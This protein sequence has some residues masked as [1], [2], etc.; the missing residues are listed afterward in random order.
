MVC[1]WSSRD[2][3]EVSEAARAVTRWA[4]SSTWRVSMADGK[5]AVPLSTV[6]APSPATSLS[7]WR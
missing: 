4:D 2:V 5:G 3:L 6:G 1:P 7:S